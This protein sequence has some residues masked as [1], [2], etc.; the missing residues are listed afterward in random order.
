MTQSREMTP[1]DLAEINQRA[2]AL[3]TRIA[4]G[5]ADAIRTAL[6]PM[7]EDYETVFRGSV[8]TQL[9]EGYASLWANPPAEL[10]KA[11]HTQVRV[12][13]FVAENI[14]SSRDFPGGYRKIVHLLS[15]GHVW[16]AFKFVGANDEVLAYDGLVARGDRWAWFPKPWRILAPGDN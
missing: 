8:G 5:P 10:A 11:V 12:F 15:P 4:H 16:C 3:L 2:V 9:A 14:A 7:P 13:A 1:A 6:Q